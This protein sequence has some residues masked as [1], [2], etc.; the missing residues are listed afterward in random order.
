[1]R[2][3]SEQYVYVRWQPN[4]PPGESEASLE[5]KQKEMKE[6]HSCEGPAGVERKHLTQLIQTTY[7]KQ[8]KA[9]SASSASSVMELRNAWLYFF[10][11]TG[12]HYKLLTDISILQNR[13]H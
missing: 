9:M 8:Y 12:L 11:Q 7:Y 4:N 1:M 2:G 3:T 5:E 13:C 6:L 10:T